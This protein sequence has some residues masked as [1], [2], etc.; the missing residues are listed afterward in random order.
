[1][2]SMEVSSSNTSSSNTSV[3]VESDTDTQASVTLIWILLPSLIKYLMKPS[4]FIKLSLSILVKLICSR[5]ESPNEG[6]TTLN[7]KV[8]R[9]CEKGLAADTHELN[10]GMLLVGFI[11]NP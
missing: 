10:V 3:S 8:R 11:F 2:S 1:M 6:V 9:L 7:V 5:V 4:A